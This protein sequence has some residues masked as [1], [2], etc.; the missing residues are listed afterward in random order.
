MLLYFNIKANLELLS[1]KHPILT[2][3]VIL[4]KDKLSQQKLWQLRMLGE[5]DFL[6]SLYSTSAYQF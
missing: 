1:T 6:N 5:L 3:Q 2:I 4:D